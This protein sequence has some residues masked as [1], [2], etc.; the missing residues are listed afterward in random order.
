[1]FLLFLGPATRPLLPSD[2]RPPRKC[3]WIIFSPGNLN[4]PIFLRRIFK[5]FKLGKYAGKLNMLNFLGAGNSNVFRIKFEF[6]SKIAKGRQIW[7]FWNFLGLEISIFRHLRG[8]FKLFE[9]FELG[10]FK[11]CQFLKF[12]GEILNCI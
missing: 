5:L 11:F 3:I 12:W 7:I 10:K 9:W 4:F 8:T 6:Y 2:I 1:M